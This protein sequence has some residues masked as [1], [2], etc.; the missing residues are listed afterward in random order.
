MWALLSFKLSKRAITWEELGT[1]VW[2][3]G[4]SVQFWSIES[5]QH[6]IKNSACACLT[7]SSS[8]D[9]FA[10]TNCLQCSSSSNMD[11]SKSARS[12][13][14][15]VLLETKPWN[16]AEQHMD[17]TFDFVWRDLWDLDLEPKLCQH[18]TEECYHLVKSCTTPYSGSWLDRSK[19]IDFAVAHIVGKKDFSD[20][21]G[22]T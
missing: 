1:V 9:V 2:R 12:S 7:Q 8:I 6:V 15:L 22:M 16:C 5:Q 21:C 4:F 3:K 13:P 20:W 10:T 17:F 14:Y 19:C 18:P 11:L